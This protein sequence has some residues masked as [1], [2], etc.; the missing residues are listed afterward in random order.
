MLLVIRPPQTLPRF[1]YLCSKRVWHWHEVMRGLYIGCLL[2]ILRWMTW[3]SAQQPSN[4]KYIIDTHRELPQKGTRMVN[5]ASIRK[6]V[7]D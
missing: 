4:S 2:N 6:G 7:E 5:M 3:N 1:E